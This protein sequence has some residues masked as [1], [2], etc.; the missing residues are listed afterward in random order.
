MD[1]IESNLLNFYQIRVYS[2]ISIYIYLKLRASFQL[3]ILC[4]VVQREFTSSLEI[5]C[6]W[7]VVFNYS[8]IDR[9]PV[10]HTYLCS[11]LPHYN[12]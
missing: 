7:Y 11:V 2:R 10:Q 1:S 5:T 4:I 3:W 8:F 9:S 12:Y 6:I